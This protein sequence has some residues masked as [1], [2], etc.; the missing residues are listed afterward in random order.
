MNTLDLRAEPVVGG[1]MAVYRRIHRANHE[2]VNENGRPKLFP[3][4]A[5]AL[6][7]AWAA[8]QPHLQSIM[9]SDGEKLRDVYRAASERF[10]QQRLCRR[11]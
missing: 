6:R 8:M 11:A 3:T 5:A 10:K 4:E 1:Y 7:A 2:T 9:H